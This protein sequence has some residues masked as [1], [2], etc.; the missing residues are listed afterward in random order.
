MLSEA[1]FDTAVCMGS[2][3]EAQANNPIV[4]DD[5]ESAWLV[6]AGTVDV[7]M[8]QQHNEATAGPRRHVLRATGGQAVFGFETN[9]NGSS[10]KLLAVG[11]LAMMLGGLVSWSAYRRFRPIGSGPDSRLRA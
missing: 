1:E 10:P 7:F 3:M 4:I 8:V 5:P 6:E 2:R 11:M 9:G